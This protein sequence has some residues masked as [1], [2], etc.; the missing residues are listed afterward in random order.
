LIR[1]KKNGI[2]WE[3]HEE[4]APLLD[5]L[6]ASAGTAIKESPAKVVTRHDVAG[7]TYY[8]KRY[9]HAAIRFR[10]LKFF[11]K[12]SQAHN[13]WR[14]ARRLQALGVPMVRHLALGERWSATGLQESIL[15]TEG[16]DGVP[17]EQ[18]TKFDVNS[19][20]AF[21]DR[22]LAAGVLQK[23][24]HPGNILVGADPRDLRLVDVHGTQIKAAITEQDRAANLAF[25][26]IF[27][28][29]P[30]PDEIAR[31]SAQ[32]R[33]DY[34]AYRSGRC[35]K[36]NREFAPKRAGGLR[37][38]V[39]LP[40]LSRQ[41]EQILEDPDGFLTAHAE[42]LKP[43]RSSTV[44]R[45]NGLVLK[46]N[47]L[48]K[49]ESLF[50]D[51]FRPSRARRAFRKSYHLELVG[52]PT[53]RPVAAADKRVLRILLRS[54]L[55]MQEIPA[56]VDLSACRGN[57][58]RAIRAVAGLVAK[59]HEEGFAHRDLKE[60]NIVFDSAGKPYLL[61]LEGL[62]YIEQVPPHR[63]ASDL[64]RLAHA[65]EP[66]EHVTGRDRWRFLTC[67]CRARGMGKK[68]QRE[69]ASQITSYLGERL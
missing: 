23:D 1:L 41:V 44:G 40:F 53:A 5:E 17:L 47:N 9:R 62:S 24:L 65:V 2:R 38:Q 56:A 7:R 67:Y 60:T 15:I 13:E 26:R 12:R 46:R 61:D 58:F 51:L 21:V 22:L 3:L 59:L 66:W 55:L 14:V 50:K 68:V 29:L 48:R 11:F 6:L 37:W 27:V 31:L 28:E 35:L 16:F 30:L 43:G 4:F 42:I 32:M 57:K 49:V 69:L 34:Y 64:A 33:R 45:A 54:Y 63:A 8:V 20:L 18:T 10:P 52:I 25:L 39:R 19:L 36:H